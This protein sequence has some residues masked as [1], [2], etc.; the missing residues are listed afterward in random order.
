MEP[1]M[2]IVPP[3]PSKS[4][5]LRDTA[6]SLGLHDT[7]QFGPRSIVAETKSTDGLQH[8]LAHWEETQDNLKLTMLRDLYGLHA[9]ARLLMERRAVSTNPHMPALQRSNIHLDIL[10]GRDETLDPS[11]FFLGMESGP[12]LNTHMEMERKL[13]M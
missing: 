10:M 5:S 13:Q 12:S 3:A 7:L 2:R 11:D 8:R 1:S 9:P 6:G 4:A